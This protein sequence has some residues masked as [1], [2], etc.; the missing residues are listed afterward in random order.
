[1]DADVMIT[2]AFFLEVFLFALAGAVFI[3]REARKARHA[4]PAPATATVSAETTASRATA[5][6]HR[7]ARGVHS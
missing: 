6:A 1:M 4:E 2:I 3:A 5:R 7:A